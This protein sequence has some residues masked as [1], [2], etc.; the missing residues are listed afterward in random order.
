MCV[1]IENKHIKQALDTKNIIPYTR[2]VNILIIYD[3]TRTTA[4]DIHKYINNTHNSLQF[5][6][7]LENKKQINFLDLNITK[8]TNKLE[9]DIDRKTT[10]TDTTINYLSNHPIEHKLAAYR[11]HINRMI[12]LPLT[13]Q[14]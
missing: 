7:T 13:K 6:P 4:D 12:E 14:K 2:F 5:S 9:I 8:K 3:N 11:Y 1:N 10:T